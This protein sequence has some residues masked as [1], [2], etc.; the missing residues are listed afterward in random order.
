MERFGDATAD[1]LRAVARKHGVLRLRVFGS[2]A[3]GDRHAG[4]DLDLLVRMEPG[5]TLW[6]LSRLRDEMEALTGL[7]IDLVT[8]GGL[9]PYICDRVL[10]EAVPV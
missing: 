5:R 9:S 6:D 1:D 2:W 4:S 10:A 8:E 3:R 7:Q